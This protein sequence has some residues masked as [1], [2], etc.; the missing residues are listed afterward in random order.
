MV[1]DIAGR[2]G[3]DVAVERIDRRSVAVRMSAEPAAGNL[4][5]EVRTTA[6]PTLAPPAPE[7]GC[8]LSVVVVLYNMKREAARTLLALSRSYQRGVEG[9]SY[10]VIVVENGSGVSTRRSAPTSSPDSVPSSATSTS[11]TPPLR[12]RSPR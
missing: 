10:E 3:R 4:Q 7:D 1:A 11:A 9:L 5:P 8:D 2:R 12:R 6:G